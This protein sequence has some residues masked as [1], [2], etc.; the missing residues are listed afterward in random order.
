MQY[1]P[2]GDAAIGDALVNMGQ[3]ELLIDTQGNWG[4]ILTGDGAAASRYIEARPTKFALEIAFNPQ[5]TEW[6][7]SYDGRKREPIHLPVKFPL[8]LA[9]G[10]E[11]IAVGLST[12]ILPHNFI[13]II[14]AAIKRLKN[15]EVII[16]PDF[17]TGGF[18]DITDYQ[19]GKRGSRVKV[20]A[21]IEK[22]DNDNDCWTWTGSQHESGAL[23]GAW[24]HGVQQMTQARRLV[25]MSVNNEDVQPYRVTM[26]C[27]NQKC[28]NPNHFKLKETRIKSLESLPNWEWGKDEE[29]RSGPGSSLKESSETIRNLPLIFK[30]YNINTVLD[31]SCGDFNWMKNVDLSKVEYLGTDIVDDLIKNNIINYKKDNINFKVM[32]FIEDNIPKVDL[33]ISRDTLFHFSNDDI[34]KSIANIKRSESKYLLTTSYANKLLTKRP[35]NIDIE[36]GGWKFLNLELSPFNFPQPIER[37]FDFRNEKIHQDRSMSL[38]KISDL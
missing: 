35:T 18:I 15:Q 9:Q 31:L 33:L 29:S 19:Q 3:K 10:A 27:K 13:E 2:H 37:F 24:R 38:W 28:C 34:F 16:Y 5:T 12:K 17:Q 6:Q 4:N 8:L 22:T 36:T 25:W 20:R 26:M 21:K 11:G 7:L 14:E 1:H 30:K 32:N 23:L